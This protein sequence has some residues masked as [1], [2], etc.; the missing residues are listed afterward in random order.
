[1]VTAPS[2]CPETGGAMKMGGPYWSAPIHDQ[3]TVDTLLDRAN[4]MAAVIRAQRGEGGKGEEDE[5]DEEEA[6]KLAIAE[7]GEGSSK[8]G[9]GAVTGP[10]SDDP[11]VPATL[12]RI[13]A[14]L[15]VIS[16]ELKD[17][18]LY[19]IIGNLASNLGMQPPTHDSISWAVA[20]LGFARFDHHFAIKY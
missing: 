15:G 8:S 17:V 11:T 10:V 1:M 13:R 6:L 2:V 7:G 5:M 18:P 9:T 16:G 3:E 12:P 14:L 19:Y 4:G 20:S